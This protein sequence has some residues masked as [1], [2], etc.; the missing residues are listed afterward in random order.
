[1]DKAQ[2]KIIDGLRNSGTSYGQIAETMQIPVSTI[3]SYC[4]RHY[5]EKEDSKEDRE[6]CR[7]CGKPLT[8]TPG[9]KPK[10]FCC[11]ECRHAWWNSHQEDNHYNAKSVHT[12]KCACC[13]KVFS[14]YGNNK[15]KYCSHECYI[16]DR[17][18]RRNE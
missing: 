4:L 18:K 11:E 12:F 2:K 6:H 1:M 3:K 7:N 5:Q 14:A 8:Q 15:R 9:T 16:T 10:R 13:G 17:F